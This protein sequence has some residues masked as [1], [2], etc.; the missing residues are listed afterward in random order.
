MLF[1]CYFVHS[2]TRR[3]GL[4]LL[5]LFLRNNNRGERPEHKQIHNLRADVPLF[6]RRPR[7]TN[8]SRHTMTFPCELK[9][10]PAVSLPNTCVSGSI[11][12]LSALFK[13]TTENKY[14]KKLLKDLLDVEASS[15]WRETL[16]PLG[17][18]CNGAVWN[19]TTLHSEW[20][21][22]HAEHC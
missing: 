5:L 8:L 12:C 19:T 14:A 7:K 9:H 2:L 17:R 13:S 18:R 3:Q 11:S 1:R 21:E 16:V 20:L 15:R 6:L 10:A 22:A 4:S